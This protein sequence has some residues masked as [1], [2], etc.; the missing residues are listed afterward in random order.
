VIIIDWIRPIRK[1]SG[2]EPTH[3]SKMSEWSL[4]QAYLASLSQF[5]YVETQNQTV[6]NGVWTQTRR[7]TWA[8]WADPGRIAGPCTK[9]IL[10]SGIHSWWNEHLRLGRQNAKVSS[11]LTRKID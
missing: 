5:I 3:K 6:G 4:Q 10:W 1:K 8:C 9:A 2:T 11:Q 7:S